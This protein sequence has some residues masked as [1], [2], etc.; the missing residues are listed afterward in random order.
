MKPLSFK[1]TFEAAIEPES[2]DPE[3]VDRDRGSKS[4]VIV[5]NDVAVKHPQDTCIGEWMVAVGIL[6]CQGH[7]I[8]MS[9]WIHRVLTAT[10]VV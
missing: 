1:T 9:S 2:A 4:A 3:E 5:V 10:D 7:D 8:C 6:G